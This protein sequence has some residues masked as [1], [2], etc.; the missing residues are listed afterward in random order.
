MG[1]MGL[2]GVFEQ[3]QA[4]VAAKLRDR[5][6]VG[7]LAVEMDRQDRLHVRRERG[8]KLGRAKVE[9]IL[10]GLDEHRTQ[11]VFR[12]GEDRCDVGVGRD[13]DTVA[14]LEQAEL[15]PAAQGEDEGRK[16][17]G[18]PDAVRRADPGGVLGLEGLH[19]FAKDVPTGVDDPGGGGLQLGGVPGVDGLEV[20]EGD[21]HLRDKDFGI[22]K[23]NLF[24][25][26]AA[27]RREKDPLLCHIDRNNG[28]GGDDHVADIDRP[29]KLEILG[30]VDAP[31][32]G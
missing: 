14:V 20:E 28:H 17:V 10:I 5:R 7:Q 4:A 30:G 31:S 11:A 19:F 32:A 3:E 16:S 15:L 23:N 12:D 26:Y 2:G 22:S 9:R 21:F 13:R 29:S 25:I 8:R 1:A 18:S 27:N 6:H 24:V